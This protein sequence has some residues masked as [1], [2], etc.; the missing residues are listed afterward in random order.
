MTLCCEGLIY[1]GS[2][3]GYAKCGRPGAR[4]VPSANPHRMG[5]VLC[6]QCEARYAAD[7][8]V[9][10]VIAVSAVVE[11]LR[12]RAEAHPG[13][14]IKD[15]YVRMK[16]R[17]AARDFERVSASFDQAVRE[18]GSLHKRKGEST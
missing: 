1:T 12:A 13:V 16:L 9:P 2:E 10:Q 4:L 11:W 5:R 15:E 18:V 6:S 17:E 8:R 7:E 14:R 3:C